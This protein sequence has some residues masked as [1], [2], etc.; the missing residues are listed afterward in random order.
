MPP[1]IRIGMRQPEVP[2]KRVWM[3]LKVRVPRVPHQLIGSRQS[4]TRRRITSTNTSNSS[5]DS[6][7]TNA[8]L[9]RLVTTYV[10]KDYRGL[11][12]QPVPGNNLYH[13][14]RIG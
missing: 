10:R 6:R 12:Q 8:L 2:S 7:R 13:A 14:G 1:P 5:I 11:R 9:A 3:Q 4:S